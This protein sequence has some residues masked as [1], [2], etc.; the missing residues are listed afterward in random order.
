MKPNNHVI[1]ENL[2][3]LSRCTNII[4]FLNL[5]QLQLDFM[6]L[7]SGQSWSKMAHARNGKCNPRLGRA[8]GIIPGDGHCILANLLWESVAQDGRAPRV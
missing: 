6:A 2:I 1:F 7:G 3:S 8:T 5:M 4:G